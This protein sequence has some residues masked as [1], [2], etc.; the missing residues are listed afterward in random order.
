MTAAVKAIET[1]G[2]TVR[3][4]DFIALDKVSLA[5]K[6]GTTTGL[7]GPNGAGKTTLF[8]TLTGDL[9]PNDGHIHLNGRILRKMSPDESAR[10]GIGKLFQDV[11]VFKNLTVFENLLVACQNNGERAWFRSW[12]KGSRELENTYQ[13]RIETVLSR[14]G[15]AASANELAG[16]L[17]FGNQKALGLGRLL[18][19]DFSIFLL[20]EP[21]AGLSP[22]RSERMASIIRE[23]ARKK[24]KTILIIEHNMQHV[25]ALCDKTIALNRGKVFAES[26][27]ADV[28]SDPSV[29][30]ICLGL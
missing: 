19:G 9:R 28:L 29:R 25:K 8:H 1:D 3:F 6:A 10:Q 27:T 21:M 5:L 11:R 18:A 2:L 20:D 4:G 14:V 30:D 26:A 7:I 23:E 12:W 15:L 24:D 13:D 17:S 22:A 16:R